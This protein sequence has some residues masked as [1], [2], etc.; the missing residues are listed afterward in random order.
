MGSLID[1]EML[2][3]FAV[4]ADP[5]DLPA[6]LEQRY[7]GLADHLTL[8]VPF[9]PGERDDF[10]QRLLTELRQRGSSPPH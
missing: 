1:D 8:Y 7:R 4:I 3:A 9:T 5:E 10:W 2:A 6:A